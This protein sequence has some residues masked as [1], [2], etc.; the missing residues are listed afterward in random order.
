[1]NWRD[2]NVEIGG[3]MAECARPPHFAWLGAGESPPQAVDGGLGSQ[4]A[5]LRIKT[6]DLEVGHK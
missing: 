3:T 4:I 5:D 6:A 2:E 1:M